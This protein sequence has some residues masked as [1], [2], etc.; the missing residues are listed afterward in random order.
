MTVSEKGK[1]ARVPL[2]RPPV[3]NCGTTH[4]HKLLA[5]VDPEYRARRRQAEYEVKQWGARYGGGG[6]RVGVMRI[7][8]VVQWVCNKPG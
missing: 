8:V 7:P 6:L 4:M 2:V 5:R 1:D 3:R